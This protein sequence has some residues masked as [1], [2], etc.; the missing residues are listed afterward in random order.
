L[1][2][3]AGIPARPFPST[4]DVF[5]RINARLVH[6]LLAVAALLTFC[7]SFLVCADVIGR[8]LFNSPVKGTP[9]IVSMSIVIICFLLAG[10]SVQSGSMLQAD[11]LVGL[12]G[13]RGP[14]ISVFLSGVLGAALFALIVWGSIEPSLHAWNSGEFE[15]EGALRIPVWPARFVVMFGSLLVA[16]TYVAQA[17]NAAIA[18][19]GPQK[20]DGA[21]QPGSMGL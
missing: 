6:V 16:I 20:S 2:S 4:I 3:G 15:G 18:I 8:V 7:L 9:E 19:F 21:P 17:V 5:D 1:V 12:F 11:I 13:P 10:Y 14:W